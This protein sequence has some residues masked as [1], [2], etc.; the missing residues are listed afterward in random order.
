MGICGNLHGAEKFVNPQSWF[1]SLR[2]FPDQPKPPNRELRLI[3][4]AD[5]EDSRKSTAA[6]GRF[7][8]FAQFCTLGT[9]H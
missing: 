3:A 9:A 4:A 2:H 5:T 7:E 8:Q 6:P 1:R